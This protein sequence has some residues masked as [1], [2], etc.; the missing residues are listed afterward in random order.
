VEPDEALPADPGASVRARRA[1]AT[2][3]LLSSLGA[4]SMLPAFVSPRFLT[5]C[6]AGGMIASTLAAWVAVGVHLAALRQYHLQLSGAVVEVSHRSMLETAVGIVGTVEAAIFAATAVGFLGWLFR[7][8]VNVRA[9]GVRKPVYGRIWSVLGFLVP[10]LNF[11]R[12]YQVM[13]EIWRA[14]DPS[15]LDPFEWRHVDP[16][17]ILALFWSSVVVAATLELMAFGFGLSVGAVEFKA[18]LASGISAVA[19]ASAALS[20]TLGFFVVTRLGAA[21]LAKCGRLL[22]HLQ[23]S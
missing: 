19:D 16:P 11:L 5:L 18:L 8:R 22:R 7:L 1:A 10:V 12:P 13:A 21:Q 15:V 4:E 6:V 17:R 9:L 20:A 2:P 23:R 14:S 3:T